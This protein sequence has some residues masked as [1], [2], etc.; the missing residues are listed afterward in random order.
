[1]SGRGWLRN[2]HV[3]RLL[4]AAVGGCV[5]LAVIVVF[6]SW[7]LGS[8]GFEA[9][10]R[11]EIVKALEDATG[12][13]AELAAVHVH[14]WRL[15][16]EAEGLVLH[17]KEAAGEAPLL[18]VGR[19]EVRLG[20]RALF[21]DAPHF[22]S[23]NPLTRRVALEL[24]RV[25]RPAAH[26][27]VYADG[28]TNIP[29]AKQKA[30]SGRP[31]ADT[32]LD[33]EAQQVELVDGTL[34]LNQ[35]VLPLNLEARGFAIRTEYRRAGDVYD[36]TV[37]MDGMQMRAGE[38]PA[39]TKS[40]LAAEVETGR[41]AVK[42]KHL[43]FASGDARLEAAGEVV[44]FTHPAWDAQ[45]SGGMDL[46]QVSLLTGFAGLGG[47]AEVQLAAKGCEADGT[48]PALAA[49]KRGARRKVAIAKSD[50]ECSEAFDVGGGVEL[51]GVDFVQPYIQ[52]HG[53]NGRV[54]VRATPE[55]LLLE[56]MDLRLPGDG[57]IR[58]GMKIEHWLSAIPHEPHAVIEVDTRIPL[59]T[60]MD[61][62]AVPGY[63]DLGFD[64]AE[65]GPVHVEFDYDPNGRGVVVSGDLKFAPTGVHRAGAL[66]DVPLTGTAA[67]EYRGVD[68][69]V[70]VAA[71]HLTSPASQLDA[72]GMLGVNEGDGLTALH[73]ELTTHELGEFDQLFRTLGL[74]YKGRHGMETVPLTLHGDA[75]FSGTAS[76][77]IAMLDVK[78]HVEAKNVELLLPEYGAAPAAAAPK[79]GLGER[80][81]GVLH[82]KKAAPTVA[83]ALPSLWQRRVMI[84]SV[85]GDADYTPAQ[86]IIKS[87]TARRGGTAVTAS[88][89][90]LMHRVV[91][92][93]RVVEYDWDEM[94]QFEGRVDV[95]GGQ[96][97]DLMDVAGVKLPLTGS[98]KLSAQASGTFGAMQGAGAVELRDGVVAGE[99]FRTMAAKLGVQ[100]TEVRA[101][102]ATVEMPAGVLHGAGV[103]DWQSGR[104][105]GNANGSGLRLGRLQTV[106][107]LG[108]GLDGSMDLA[109]TADGT[110]VEPGLNAE[111]K[112]SGLQL[113]GE[114]IGS[115]D[116]TAT[117]HNGVLQVAATAGQDARRMTLNGTMQ[118]SGAWQTDARVELAQFDADGLLKLYVPLGLTGHSSVSGTATLAGPLCRPAELRGAAELRQLDINLSGIELGLSE[119]AHAKLDKGRLSV[120]QLHITG[121]DT[122]LRASGWAQVF[123]GDA[124]ALHAVGSVNMRLMQSADADILSSGHVDL[125]M[126]A[127]GS[128]SNPN[129]SGTVKFRNVAIALEDLPNGLSDINGTLVFNR[130]RL[131][132]QSLTAMT[133]GG[134][135]S[136]GGFMSL[137]N[138]FYADLTATGDNVRVRYNGLSS[139]ANASLRMQGSTANALLS[140]NVLITRFGVGPE[141]DFAA[142]AGTSPLD[143]PP[144]D[145]HAPSSHVRLDVRVTSASELDF[146]N[147]Y[148]KLAGHVDLTLAGTLATPTVLGRITVTDGSARFAGQLYDLQRGNVTFN[149]PVRIDPMIDLDA[150]TRVENYDVTVGA[151]GLL[152]NLKPVYRSEPPLTEADIFSLLALGRT[153]EEAQ[154]YQQ[155]NSLGGDPTTNAVLGGALTATVGNRVG[156]LFGSGNVKIDPSFVGT[157]GT[158]AA[159]IT[160]EQPLGRNLIVTYATNVNQTAQQ[161]IQ[162]QVNLTDS[163]SVVATRDES[164]VFS[165][166]L[167]IRKRYH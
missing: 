114:G 98:V 159:R 123:G 152:S 107:A 61:Y 36:T 103:Y 102:E 119:A 149:N 90:V 70:R 56:P 38:G 33:V 155:Q 138:G 44:N 150:T 116:V 127:S 66:S 146:Q 88:G 147:S 14:P 129:L 11:R 16:A 18:S 165:T 23:L 137:K 132:V 115:A 52:V 51:H 145:P 7:Y 9:R 143:M 148:A 54:A 42:L 100:G 45:V 75:H 69:T 15:D 31:M 63:G 83:T 20:L 158:S 104:M 81:A 28:S 29:E 73:T 99:S 167:K 118:M 19:I 94:A 12:G 21:T 41:Q 84:D 47:R 117:S 65:S 76:G 144:A 86:L 26:L 53:L 106:S 166:V 62:V 163:V 2:K 43:E 68:Q 154:V 126:D 161:L 136:I 139:T 27:I 3:R 32:L 59:R 50:G 134:Q 101:T 1:M 91:G 82:L 10:L 130:D 64:T 34:I 17:G 77:L 35:R 153:A 156:R 8:A 140:G 46:E 5:L 25:E 55:A 151:H 105:W 112:V 22:R 97:T 24:L 87:A 160:V 108:V 109:A 37:A 72:S 71:L 80:L 6:W 49:T 122:N 60:I 125:K 57:S 93:H 48:A 141:F 120:D 164:G 89:K 30:P 39:A 131:E 78:G 157:L 110:A 85:V 4:A 95:P 128:V 133:G 135:L 124:L 13:R 111:A 96:A 121:E 142:F 113:G 79:P 40:H 74:E 92:P 162:L 67:A 58:G